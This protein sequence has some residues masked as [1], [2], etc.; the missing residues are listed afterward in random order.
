[1]VGLR[2]QEVSHS[3]LRHSLIWILAPLSITPPLFRVCVWPQAASATPSNPTSGEGYLAWDAAG[4]QLITYN[5][6]AWATLSGGGGYNLIKDETT[7]LTVRTT[8]AF[9]GG[10]CIVC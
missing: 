10:W 8:L 9:L 5:G 4:N 3:R 6:S 7:S 1:M 2:W